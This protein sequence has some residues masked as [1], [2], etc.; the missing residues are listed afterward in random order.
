MKV[1]WL[2]LMMCGAAQAQ[3]GWVM[4]AETEQMTGYFRPGDAREQPGGTYLFWAAFDYKVPQADRARS[5]R[6]AWDIDCRS[7]Q[8][9]TL[10]LTR[11]VGVK[12]DGAVVAS[13][14]KSDWTPIP[15]R[16]GVEQAANTVCPSRKP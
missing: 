10:H 9:R 6:L 3:D 7:M 14:T 16:S 11:H 15:P 1:L 2:L 12:G 5:V 8:V 13:G 4:I